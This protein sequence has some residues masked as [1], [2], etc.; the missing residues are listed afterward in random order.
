[1][2]PQVVGMHFDHVFWRPVEDESFLVCSCRSNFEFNYLHYMN[3]YLNSDWMHNTWMSSESSKSFTQLGSVMHIHTIHSNCH[4][5]IDGCQKI[6][7][8][9]EKFRLIASIQNSNQILIASQSNSEYRPRWSSH[10][11]LSFFRIR[12]FPIP[13]FKISLGTAFGKLRYTTRGILNILQTKQAVTI[14]ICQISRKEEIMS[15]PM[16]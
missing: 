4:P 14:R 1:M 3:V 7:S 13:A 11:G 12:H 9:L 2:W 16:F 8:I 10:C 15:Q 6:H 5:W